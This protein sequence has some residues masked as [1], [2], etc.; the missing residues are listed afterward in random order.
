[1]PKFRKIYSQNSSQSRKTHF[2]AKNPHLGGY[3][4][5]LRTPKRQGKARQGNRCIP[6]RGVTDQRLS[7]G[8]VE[9]A[10]F[11]P[12]CGFIGLDGKGR[13]RGRGWS[14]R[15]EIQREHLKIQGWH[16][17][18]YT[19]AT[20]NFN[21]SQFATT[22]DT[23]TCRIDQ[24]NFTRWS[25]QNGGKLWMT[26]I[27]KLPQYTQRYVNNEVTTTPTGL[28]RAQKKEDIK[29]WRIGRDLTTPLVVSLEVV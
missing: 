12:L 18:E 26:K 16:I 10:I 1:M 13:A 15:G 7:G 20:T 19:V 14:G 27:C 28:R 25:I 11:R 21:H 17:V 3:L 5:A 8:L 29:D 4:G 6:T 22:L 9:S 24:I 23:S 2:W